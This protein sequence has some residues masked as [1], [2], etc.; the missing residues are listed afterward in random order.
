MRAD[1]GGG[2]DDDRVQAAGDALPHLALAGSLGAV[3]GCGP[4]GSELA[5]AFAR[6]GTRVTTIETGGIAKG[7]RYSAPHLYIAVDGDNSADE[8]IQIWNVGNAATPTFTG[9]PARVN[10]DGS[11]RT[12]VL[13][14]SLNPS[15]VAS[16]WSSSP[17]G[18]RWSRA[19]RPWRS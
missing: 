4:I 1:H 9:T 19:G 6:L 5:Q 7:V 15:A 8:G 14:T 13:P 10:A 17:A 11:M 16:R 2:V 3:V 12:G 18:C